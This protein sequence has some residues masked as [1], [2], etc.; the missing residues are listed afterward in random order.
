MIKKHEAAFVAHVKLLSPLANV[1]FHEDEV[2]DG[3]LPVFH[4]ENV[5]TGGNIQLIYKICQGGTSGGPR[6][7]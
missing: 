6:N 4:L 2:V 5:S 1:V 3:R 7:L